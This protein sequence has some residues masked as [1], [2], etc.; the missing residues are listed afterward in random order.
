MR[1]GDVNTL[2]VLIVDDERV[3]RQKLRRYLAAEP[4]VTAV[5]ECTGG[6]EAVQAIRRERPDITFLD[7]QMPD[8]DGFDVLRQVGV[9]MAGAVVLVSA[10][11]HY[12]VR[13]FEVEALDYLVK[14]FDRRRF[15]A[16]LDR[17]RR[18]AEAPAHCN[19]MAALSVTAE[20]RAPTRRKIVVRAGGRVMV[21]DADEVEWI[22]SADN[23]VFVHTARQTHRARETLAALEDRLDPHR[24][25]RIHRRVIINVNLLV[26]LRP[27]PHGGYVA[28]LQNGQ[29]LRVGRRHRGALRR[30]FLEAR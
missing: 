14:P 20:E 13:A 30:F 3:A 15:R 9:G 11:D 24:F 4:G 25:L 29:T 28:Q 23:Y 21:L 10:H 8:I 26:E 7:V 16:A 18:R 22:E 1:P 5:A 6:T 19:G 12:A 27:L 2:R 17:A